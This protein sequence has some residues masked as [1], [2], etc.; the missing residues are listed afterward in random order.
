MHFLQTRTTSCTPTIYVLITRLVA[1][2]YGQP[3]SSLFT[4][5]KFQFYGFL[6]TGHDYTYGHT[7]AKTDFSVSLAYFFGL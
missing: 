6:A 5:P 2:S 7:V 4:A 1:F 3:Y